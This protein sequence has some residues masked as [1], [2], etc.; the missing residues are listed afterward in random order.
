MIQIVSIAQTKIN[1]GY[2]IKVILLI[3]WHKN[4]LK[5]HVVW[6]VKIVKRN[7]YATSL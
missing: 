1:V 7:I 5:I 6:V 2:V 4:V 3:L